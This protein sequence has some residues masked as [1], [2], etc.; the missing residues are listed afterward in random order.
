MSE[1]TLFLAW[2]DKREESRLWFPIGRL[3]AALPRERSDGG[4]GR[5]RKL[6]GACRA[7]QSATCSVKAARSG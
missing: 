2:Q 6:C 4:N 5:T 7:D 3:D 1:K